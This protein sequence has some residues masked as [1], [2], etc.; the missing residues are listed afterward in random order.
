[1]K[2]TAIPYVFM[3]GGS[4]RGPYFRRADLPT[5][6]EQLS[7]VLLAVLG[8]GHPLNIDGIGGGDAVTTKVAMLSPSALPGVDVDYLFAQV[9]VTERLVD[10]KPT[11]G[12][13]LAGVGAAAVEL[14]IIEAAET[15]ALTIRAV[16]TGALVDTVLQTR[17]GEVIYDGDAVLPGVPG[18]AAPVRLS[19][20]DVAGSATGA[21]LPTGNPIDVID[22]I[23]VTC[24]DVAMP[25]VI[26]R[27]GDLGLRGDESAA[28][29]D[30]S[31]ALFQR[32]EAIR[33]AASQRMG[34]GDATQSVVPKLAVVAPPSEEG[35]LQARYFMPWKTHPSMAVTG[36]QCIAACALMPGTVAT[37]LLELRHFASPATI[38][39]AHCCGTIEVIMAYEREGDALEVI[40]A[41]LVRTARKLAQGEVFVGSHIWQGHAHSHS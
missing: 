14:G 36:A 32:M 13:I 6:Q 11:C 7:A 31:T 9:A 41:G 1:M 38:R 23:E 28:E 17:N 35:E 21:M 24:M 8:S 22:G 2:Q 4:S 16:N 12:N 10:Y 20:R 5:D 19:F 18:T 34:M 30:A 40:S 15:T 25:V 26:M 27:A 3:R 37:G 29:L 33:L 39:I